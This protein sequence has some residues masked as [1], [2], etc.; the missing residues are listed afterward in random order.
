MFNCSLSPP[1]AEMYEVATVL[2]GMV[3]A[4]TMDTKDAK[5][6]G[7]AKAKPKAKAKASAEST[8]ES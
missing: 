6:K 7:K 4:S 3:A 8:A 1:V 2:Q 5:A